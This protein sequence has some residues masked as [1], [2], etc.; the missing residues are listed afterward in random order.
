MKT[1]KFFKTVTNF[2]KKNEST[3]HMVATLTGLGMTAYTSITG[4]IKAVRHVDA[5]KA[6]LGKD[7]LTFKETASTVWKDYIPAAGA[8]VA[9]G[10]NAVC[11]KIDGDKKVAALA[12]TLDLT[13]T[14]Y[15]E[16]KSKVRDTIGEKEEANIRKEIAE[17]HIKKEVND[18]SELPLDLKYNNIGML[19]CRDEVTGKWFWTNSQMIDHA[20]MELTK[21]CE[22]GT[23]WLCIADLYSE[24]NVD[25]KDI[26]RMAYDLGWNGHVPSI[27]KW[28][29]ELNDGTRYMTIDYDWEP[30]RD[31]HG[32]LRYR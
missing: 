17:E 11:T 2:C 22:P 23:G 5:K 28:F 16:Y 26:G 7:K 13:T 30:E 12:T 15:N 25:H 32:D 19:P 3:L 27:S 10:A 31:T 1:N 14:A 9:T 6:E 29:G 21:E 18:S 4:T 8:I 24:L 20:L